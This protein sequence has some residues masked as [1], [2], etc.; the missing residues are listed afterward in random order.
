[1]SE[2]SEWVWVW[3]SVCCECECFVDDIYMDMMD[4][5]VCMYMYVCVC[6]SLRV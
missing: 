5:Y 3:V 1:M 4:G 6:L 2:R